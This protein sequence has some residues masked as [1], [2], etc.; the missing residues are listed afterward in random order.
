MIVDTLLYIVANTGIAL[1]IGAASRHFGFMLMLLVYSL[2]LSAGGALSMAS[3]FPMGAGDLPYL[4]G[5]DGEG[6][7]EDAVKLAG[8]G[9]SNFQDVITTNYA[10]HQIYLAGWFGLFGV[11]LMVAMVANNLLLMLSVLCL[12]KASHILT[13]QP[14]A[15]L[16]A[17]LAMMLNTSHIYHSL[18]LLK[19]PAICL[20]FSLMLLSAAE[21]LKQRG[22]GLRALAMFLAGTAIVI[23]MRGTL[24]LFVL[25]LLGFLATLFLKQRLHVLVMLAAVLLLMVPLA[26]TFTTYSLDADF[27]SETVLLNTV[28]SETLEAGAVDAGGVVGRVSGAYLAWPF[29]VKLLLFIVPTSLQLLLPFDFWSTAFLDDH[30]SA[31]FGRNLNPLWFLFVAVWALFALVKIRRLQDPLMVRLMLAGATFYVIVAVIY[32]GAIPRYGAPALYFIYPAIGHWWLRYRE[33]E[34]VREEV[35]AFFRAYY[36]WLLALL[37]PYLALNLVRA[38]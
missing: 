38:V 4:A 22:L 6:Y 9:L 10:G 20:A 3:S 29:T 28:V 21:A 7:F 8:E 15:A 18:L 19:E 16:L 26:Q 11:S 27:I 36:V 2:V 1:A 13:H 17:C 30:F 34:S 5:S 37:L 35:R 12:F 31:F 33:D 32:G 23:A 25:V 14:H 24:L